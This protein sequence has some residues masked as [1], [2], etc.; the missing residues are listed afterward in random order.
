[1]D[2]L[3]KLDQIAE[4]LESTGH[5]KLASEIDMVSN[6]LEKLAKVGDRSAPIFPA[7]HPKVNDGAEHFPIPNAAHARNALARVSQYGSAP[8]WYKGSL[9]DLKTTVR[10]AVK[11][12]FP[13]IEV[14][15]PES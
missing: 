3:N 9:E 4:T 11:R 15:E 7:T 10:N 12:K 1:M 5:V 2:I 13:S 6:S 8:S 14:S